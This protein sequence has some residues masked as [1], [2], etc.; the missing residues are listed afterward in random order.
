MNIK[1][2]N[3]YKSSKCEINSRRIKDEIDLNNPDAN[4][5]IL[6][7]VCFPYYDD[8]FR[9]NYYDELYRNGLENEE[10]YEYET[11]SSD[12]ITDMAGVIE[13][14]LG[15][16]VAKFFGQETYNIYHDD[17]AFIVEMRGAASE[18]RDGITELL[19]YA[20][21]IDIQY[22]DVHF[23]SN[24]DGWA[25]NLFGQNLDNALKAKFGDDVKTDCIIGALI[26]AYCMEFE[27]LYTNVPYLQ[28][29]VNEE[30]VN[31]VIR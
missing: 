2:L 14:E 25:W 29:L 3:A 20:D 31:E 17:Q 9:D 6:L 16:A 13:D 12:L 26:G 1:R 19:K 10:G 24:T 27:C 21:Q 28:D 8:L 30:D 18:Y 22:D 11:L 5:W 15:N 7:N 23:W 4:E